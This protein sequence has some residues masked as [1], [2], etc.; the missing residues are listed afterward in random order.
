MAVCY[1]F[2]EEKNMTPDTK[3]EINVLEEQI[4]K[5]QKNEEEAEN[6][7]IMAK[8]KTSSLKEILRLLWSK[9]GQCHHP[10]MQTS[11]SNFGSLTTRRCPD[12]NY[13]QTGA[14]EDMRD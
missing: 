3:N 1:R 7:Y 6:C 8:A 11:Y 14:V 12:C 10:N 5:A 2:L 9:N 13:S 4:K